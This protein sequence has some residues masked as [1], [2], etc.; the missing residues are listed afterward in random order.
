MTGLVTMSLRKYWS[1]KSK[2]DLVANWLI[3]LLVIPRLPI[4]V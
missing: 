2:N 3:F 4:D 1:A